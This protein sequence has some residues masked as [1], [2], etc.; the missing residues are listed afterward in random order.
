M[1]IH[2][3][4]KHFVTYSTQQR[5]SLLCSFP[6]CVSLLLSGNQLRSEILLGEPRIQGSYWSNILLSRIG[7]S[8]RNDYFMKSG[9]AHRIIF[10]NRNQPQT[11]SLAKRS[12]VPVSLRSADKIRFFFHP[13]AFDKDGNLIDG[14]QTLEFLRLY[15]VPTARSFQNHIKH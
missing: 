11:F 12:I 10:Y 7:P 4:F 8:A 9:K 3:R 13:N 14:K 5:I 6:R 15:L 1:M 2:Q